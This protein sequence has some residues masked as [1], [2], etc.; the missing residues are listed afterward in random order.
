MD[1]GNYVVLGQHFEICSHLSLRHAPAITQAATALDGDAGH[2]GASRLDKDHRTTLISI[3]L[4]VV[5]RSQ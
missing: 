4:V 2:F 5:D 3:T 1:I